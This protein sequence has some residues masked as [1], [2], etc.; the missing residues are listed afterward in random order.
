M[1]SALIQSAFAELRGR[2]HTRSLNEWDYRR[3]FAV[4]Q[5]GV[6]LALDW[7]EPHESFAEDSPSERPIIVLLHGLTASSASGYVKHFAK[8]AALRGFR[9]VVHN[10]R[11]HMPD[12]RHTPKSRVPRSLGSD[13]H[14]WHT[15]PRYGDT[16]DLH[17]VI[18]SVHKRYPKAPLYAA[19]LSAGS[20]YLTRYLAE[21]GATTPLRAAFTVANC[22]DI[23]AMA[24]SIHE[25]HPLWERALLAPM[26]ALLRSMESVFEA[27]LGRE[28][29]DAKRIYAAR[30][31]KEYDAA[32]P[33]RLY[34]YDDI[35]EYYRDNESLHC[36]PQIQTPMLH[37]AA[38]DDP[39]VHASLIPQEAFAANPYLALVTTRYGGHL[40]YPEGP[41]PWRGPTFMERAALEFFEAH[42]TA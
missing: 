12:L 21:A 26:K 28:V 20:N 25:H 18:D 31:M 35:G 15:V 13:V 19:G 40:G 32:G 4:P 14:V 5:D 3:E 33:A 11:G 34:G 17:F 37:M 6:P 42:H 10:R 27:V 36:L 29:F 2:L 16:L 41:Q 24:E 22:F 30:T 1:R 8:Q 39:V 23:M 9:V 7:T 38:L